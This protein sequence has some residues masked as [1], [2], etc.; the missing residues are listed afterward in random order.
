M[1]VLLFSPIIYIFC[2]K[3]FS[4]ILS[5]VRRI[6]PQLFP[7]HRSASLIANSR[8]LLVEIDNLQLLVLVHS[9]Y[10]HVHIRRELGLLRAV[11][12]LITRF[13][14]ALKLAVCLH[15]GQ[16]SVAAVASGTMKLLSCD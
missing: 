1:L 5:I 13:L 10:V 11:R 14:A 2:Y 8:Q 15:V 3:A 7:R 9:S 6:V 16:P 4:T 12:A